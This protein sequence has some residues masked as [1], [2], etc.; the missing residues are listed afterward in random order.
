[1]P[2]TLLSCLIVVGGAIPVGVLS[3]LPESLTVRRDAAPEGPVTMLV[4]VVSRSAL[5]G[6]L[7]TLRGAGLPIVSVSA[8]PQQ[9]E[10]DDPTGGTAR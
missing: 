3:G 10:R 5:D 7:S 8:Q 9:P 4:G 6:I 2:G 1:M